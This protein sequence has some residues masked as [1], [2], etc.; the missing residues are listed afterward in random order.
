MSAKKKKGQRKKARGRV[1]LPPTHTFGMRRDDVQVI[2]TPAGQA[3]MSDV[4]V[5]FIDPYADQWKTVEELSSLLTMGTLA[6]NAAFYSGVERE[7]FLRKMLKLI[8]S[9]FHAGV[10]EIINALIA[11]KIEHYAGIKR[12]I[13]GHEVTMNGDGPFVVVLSTLSMP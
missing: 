8:P 6:W 11:R 1:L 12:Y 5:E 4:L 13:M 9:E 7:D 3:K 2:N 10:R